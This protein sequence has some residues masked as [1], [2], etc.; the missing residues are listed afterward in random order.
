MNA[1]K[2]PKR[3]SLLRILF[4]IF[5]LVDSLLLFAGSNKKTNPDFIDMSLQ[6]SFNRAFKNK[7]FLP[8]N[9]FQDRLN[10]DSLE[11]AARRIT[12]V[13]ELRFFFDG[14]RP[15]AN[16]VTLN[17]SRSSTDFSFGLL[18]Y[19]VSS[20]WLNNPE[21]SRV[22][23]LSFE[24][25]L[26]FPGSVFGISPGM[27]VKIKR[28]AVMVSSGISKVAHEMTD[29]SVLPI[30]GYHKRIGDKSLCVDAK[31]SYDERYYSLGMY[32]LQ[33]FSLDGR[34][35]TVYASFNLAGFDIYGSFSKK[36]NLG[37]E[38]P[39][40]EHYVDDFTQLS[41][42]IFANFGFWALSFDSEKVIR[43]DKPPSRE[44]S[45]LKSFNF[46]WR[47]FRPKMEPFLSFSEGKEYPAGGQQPY[48]LKDFFLIK[49]GVILNF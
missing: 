34:S 24:R 31:L 40:I 46:Y 26:G 36:K 11:V 25:H 30:F 4:P 27:R 14:F 47:G 41:L 35:G 45:E 42:L 9:T 2:C 18:D 15:G 8:K 7:Y 49:S 43:S 22:D 23:P 16:T 21:I 33:L 1:K 44:L 39:E 12:G 10:L 5:F 38:W 17:Y 6:L 13:G 48:F 20:Y 29:S 32:W 19:P 3:F 37:S 28:G